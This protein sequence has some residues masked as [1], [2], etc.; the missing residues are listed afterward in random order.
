MID[1]IWH[2]SL[3]DR[4]RGGVATEELNQQHAPQS[5]CDLNVMGGF[6]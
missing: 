1:V 4:T 5:I 2:L 3:P 6:M